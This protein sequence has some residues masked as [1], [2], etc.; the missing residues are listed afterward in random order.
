MAAKPASTRHAPHAVRIIGGQWK[1][2]PLAVVDL[3]GL[4]PTPDRVRETVFNWIRHLRGG[5]EGARVLD[6]FAGTGALGLEA[7]SRGAASV[8]LIEQQRAAVAALSAS[9]AKL[10]AQE[11]VQLLQADALAVLRGLP[12]ASVDLAFVDPPYDAGLLPAVLAA[13][14]RVLAEEALVYVEDRAPIAPAPETGWSVTR[15]DRAGQVHFAL[16]SRTA[17]PLHDADIA[18]VKKPQ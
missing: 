14:P 7:A 1:R 17:M 5:L 18:P 4:R 3:P 12:A 13:L 16:L 15:S 8:T 10:K 6:L 9:I 11:Q 2:T